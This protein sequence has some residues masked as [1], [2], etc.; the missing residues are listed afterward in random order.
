[1]DSEHTTKLTKEIRASNSRVKYPQA[2]LSVACDA[3]SEA[4]II[5]D[6]QQS[7]CWFKSVTPKD[8]HQY[9]FSISC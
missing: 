3:T 5:L 2:L 9:L 1:M 8:L 6:E 4:M 7:V